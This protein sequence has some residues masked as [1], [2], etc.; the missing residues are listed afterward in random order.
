LRETEPTKKSLNLAHEATFT[1]PS[2]AKFFLHRENSPEK[3]TTCYNRKQTMEEE[4]TEGI[5]LRTQ[6]YK[7]CHRIITLYTPQGMTS[8]MVHGISRKNT[9]LLTLTTPFCHG[10]YVYRKGRTDLPSFRDG[11]ILG[12]GMIL[13][14]KLTFLQTAGALAN[15][16]LT[17]QMPGKASPALYLLYRSCHQQVPLFPHPG[18]LLA[19]F[20][21]KLLKHE[22]LLTISTRCS[23]C[24]SS[25][26]VLYEGESFCSRHSPPEEGIRFLPQEWELLLALS[27]AREFSSLKKLSVPSPLLH[28]ITA[29]F[30]SRLT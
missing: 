7:E 28:K 20:Y 22:G 17:S 1:T 23:V 24:D 14:Q 8:L 29:L 11:S 16:I 5:V 9:H 26:L 19:S 12:D 6:D 15:A 10:E 2:Y 27:D 21:L 18:A 25:P 13:R 30:Q 3:A 4:K